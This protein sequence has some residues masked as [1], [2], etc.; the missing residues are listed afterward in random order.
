M[1]FNEIEKDVLKC[2]NNEIQNCSECS[3]KNCNMLDFEIIKSQ[4]AKKILKG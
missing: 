3:F 1:L 4:L 2:L